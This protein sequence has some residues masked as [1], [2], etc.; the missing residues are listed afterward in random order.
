MR[1]GAG[2]GHGDA[3]VDVEREVVVDRTV[4]VEDAAVPVVGVFVD[5][6]IGH[7]H[8]AVADG[9]TY[10]AQGHLHDSVWVERSRPYGILRGGHTEQHERA[11]TQ[12][13]QRP[14][15]VDQGGPRVLHHPR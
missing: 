12:V 9:L 11:H 1:T 13:G 4:A 3:R 8:H 2:L 6:Q 10:V 7:H 15:L 5:A 14:R